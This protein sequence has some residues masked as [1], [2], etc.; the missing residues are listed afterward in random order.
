VEIIAINPAFTALIG[1][2]NYAQEKDISVHQGAA[3]ASARSSLVLFER[4][5]GQK[6][7]VPTRNGDQVTF[8]RPVRNRSK[9]VWSFV[10]KTRTSLKAAPVAHFQLGAA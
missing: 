7:T 4:P 5:G 6:A 9:Q 2:V 8:E 3:L 10:S 1:A